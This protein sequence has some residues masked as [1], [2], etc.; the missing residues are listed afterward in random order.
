MMPV[1]TIHNQSAAHKLQEE[2]DGGLAIRSIFGRERTLLHQ[3]LV[4][5]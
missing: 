4:Y 2:E 5:K 1:K 3:D